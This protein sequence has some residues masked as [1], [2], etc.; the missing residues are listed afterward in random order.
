M[1]R[2][3]SRKDGNQSEIIKG[4][5]QIGAK[6]HVLDGKGIGDLLVGFRNELSVLELKDGNKPLSQRKRRPSQ[7][8]FHDDWQ[9]YRIYK[10]ESIEEALKVI[11]AVK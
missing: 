2:Y 3:A 10:V 7:K 5:R 4:L 8:K 9:G 11:G 1:S 6:V